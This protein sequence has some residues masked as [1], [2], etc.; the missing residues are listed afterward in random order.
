MGVRAWRSSIGDGFSSARVDS[1]IIR[2][3]GRPSREIRT[4][5]SFGLGRLGIPEAS[6]WTTPVAD[7]RLRWRNPE[8]A[9]AVELRVQR[10]ALGTTPL[11]VANQAMRNEARLSLEM[12]LGELRVR[13]G[14][15][16]AQVRSR[17]EES[18]ARRQGDAALVLPFGWQG[19]VSLQYHR[20]G[21]SRATAAGY[22]APR[23]VETLEGGTY[24]ELGGDGRASLAFDLG[25]G[26]QRLA[27]QE[28]P[29]G[30]WKLALRGWGMLT[31]DIAPTLQWRVEAEAYNAPF[32]P[33]GAVT[34]PNW[35]FFSVTT[36]LIFRLP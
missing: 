20:L 2:L 7:F 28:E 32:A 14:G 36:S 5:L 19:E 3:E 1:G 8:G 11:L 17:V 15:R 24:W 27:K 35:R 13:V 25:A 4:D 22:F 26:I 9:P 34:T 21:F 29:A 16:A 12:P 23:R 6:S 31:V 30:P 33:V 10:L 18:N